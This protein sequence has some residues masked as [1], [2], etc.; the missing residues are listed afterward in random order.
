MKGTTTRGWAV[1][2]IAP[3]PEVF[4]DLITRH[5]GPVV[6]LNLLKFKADAG[7]G[8]TGAEAYAAYGAAVTE[9]IRSRGG[10]VLWSGRAEAMLIGGAAD[11]WDMV[12]LVRYPSPLTLAEMGASP[13]YQ[14][15]HHHREAGLERTTLIACTELD[16]RAGLYNKEIRI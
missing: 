7:D 4:Q 3:N 13:E 16:I 1:S 14:S 15:V 2:E 11:Q 6:M 8:R 9:M 10:E 5:A 12:A